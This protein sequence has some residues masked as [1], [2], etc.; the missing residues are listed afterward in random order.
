MGEFRV[1]L[2]Y[3]PFSYFSTHSSLLHFPRCPLFTNP[4][5]SVSATVNT[6]GGT[7]KGEVI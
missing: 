6:G 2:S 3:G 5:K 7:V 1:F 4:Q